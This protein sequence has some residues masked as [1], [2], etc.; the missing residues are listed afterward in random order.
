MENIIEPNNLFD[1]SS[2]SLANPTGIQGGAYFTRIQYN[3][4]SLYIQ[5]P[6]SQTKQGFVKNG[7]KIYT[8]LMFD[9]NNEQ[10][11]QWI[12]N[13]EI[14]CQQL[15][16][17][18]GDLWFESQLE[19]SDIE[20]AFTTPMRIYKSG[21]KYLIRVNVKLNN[22]NNIP[23]AKIYNE[24]E[25]M[26]STDDVTSDTNIISILEIQ[27]IKFTTRNFQIE[28]E[29]KQTM[30]LNTEILFDNCLIKNKL[31]GTTNHVNNN[32]SLN[33]KDKNIKSN[34]LE[35][36][37]KEKVSN[38]D[39]LE[40]LSNDILNSENIFDLEIKDISE[41]F[42]NTNNNNIDD[43]ELDNNESDEDESDEDDSDEENPKLVVGQLLNTPNFNNNE[44]EEL[45]FNFQ[46][47][48]GIREIEDITPISNTLETITLKKPNQVY[49]ELYKEAKK[50]AKENKKL[51]IIAFLEA[52]NIKK[53]YMLDN[54]NESD[55]E[56][57]E[58]FSKEIN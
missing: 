36:R 27:G 43:N 38:N 24:D 23:T 44:F 7:K 47:I 6:K 49:Y 1:F 29:M 17:E 28:I 8:D 22:I 30:V 58:S 15:I 33:I 14:K 35:E 20:S 45:E 55:D 18:K 2:L 42:T 5:T 37:G 53:T 3:G 9:N 46:E 4:K 21:K 26:L 52:K 51:A 32:I 54:L 25:V 10:F 39:F 50:R 48:E 57:E 11:I 34:L 19:K 41:N 56:T 13:L 16:Y 31:N 40:S 12:E